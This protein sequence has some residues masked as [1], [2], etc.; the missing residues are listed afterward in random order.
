MRTTI[1]NLILFLTVLIATNSAHCYVLEYGELYKNIKN[2]LQNQTKNEILKYSSDFE[3]NINGIPK[4][5]ILTN[6]STAPKIEIIS[7][8]EGFLP[9]SFKRVYIKDSKG[10]VVKVFPINVHTRIYKNVLVA[11]NNIP[12]GSEINKENTIIQRSEVSRNLSNVLSEIPVGYITKRNFQKGNLITQDSIKSQAVILKNSIVNIN[13]VSKNGLQIKVQGKAL[14][15]GAIGETILVK[16]DKYNKT[17]NA[18][19]S[20]ASQVTVRI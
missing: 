10:N 20:S 16:S 8:N 19:V 3:I 9:N 4:E 1:K 18:I 5:K 12:F 2:H 6:D 13:F 15:D 17:Y 7:Q 11:Q 14:K